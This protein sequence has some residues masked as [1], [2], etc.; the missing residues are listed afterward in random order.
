LI[1]LKGGPDPS[2]AGLPI[3]HM[4]EAFEKWAAHLVRFDEEAA[5]VVP[6]RRQ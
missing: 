3:D 4:R 1:W 2:A 6:L 5:N